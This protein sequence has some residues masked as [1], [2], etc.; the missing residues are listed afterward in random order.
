MES[1]ELHP[2]DELV[3][4]GPSTGAHIFKAEELRLE[5]EPVGEVKKGDTF[6]MPVPAKIRPGDRL[7]LWL[8]K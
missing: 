8:E 3:L 5:V 7:Y 2:G 4:T 1:G 6:S